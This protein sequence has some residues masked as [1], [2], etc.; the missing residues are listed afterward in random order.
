MT[1]RPAP[2]P[3]AVRHCIV[4]E[5]EPLAVATVATLQ[6]L[7]RPLLTDDPDDPTRVR[8]LFTWRPAPGDPAGG[9]YL[10]VN[11]LTDKRHVARGMMRRRAAS[12]LWFVELAVPRDVLATYRVLPLHAAGDAGTE[13]IPPPR[14]L[15]RR[16]RIDPHNAAALANSPFGSVLAGPDAPRLDVWT[17]SP[18]TTST[19]LDRTV[20]LAP[21]PLRYRLSVPSGAGAMDLVIAFDAADVWLDRFRLPDVLAAAGRRCAVLG[22][23]SPADPS[24]RLRFLGAHDALFPAIT[25]DALPAARMVTGP[26]GRVTIAGQSLGGL[27]ALAFAA[28]NPDLV[29]EVLAYSPSV[30]WR[31]GL[32]G[33]P[34]D[35]T[36][37]HGWIHDVVRGCPPGGFS[38]RLASGAFE[39]ELT[40]GVRDLAASARAAGHDVEHTVY[41][42]G[43]DEAQWAAL[44]LEHLAGAP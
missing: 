5:V 30:W 22:I 9:A 37:R 8:A 14:E 15:L 1:V 13:E 24:E 17:A 44:L 33:R 25:E 29:D 19:A 10:W 12:D 6:S 18:A 40:P 3:D 11:R 39:E 38:I 4:H 41:S 26:L 35:V 23:D 31:P 34:S 32:T 43:H 16:A 42:G 28:R 2:S 27:A 7:G 36:E 20:D 21:A